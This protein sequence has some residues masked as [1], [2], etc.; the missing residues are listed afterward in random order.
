MVAG[1]VRHIG[2]S[3]FGVSLLRDLLSYAAVR[4]SMLQV[5]LHPYLAQEKLLRYCREEKIGVTG[6]SPLGAGSYV[7]LGMPRQTIPCWSSRMSSKL[8]RTTAG[9]SRSCSAGPCSAAR[10]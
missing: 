1:L 6:F 9:R 2:V 5:E 10:R 3:N 8:Q 4:P 7:P